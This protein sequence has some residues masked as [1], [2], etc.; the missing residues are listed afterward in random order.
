M[1][2]LP[3]QK[4]RHEQAIREADSGMIRRSIVQ[5]EKILDELKRCSV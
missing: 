3:A 1:A 4:D 5:V 2:S